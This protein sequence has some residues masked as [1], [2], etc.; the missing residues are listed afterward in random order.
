MTT[1]F[2]NEVAR[3]LGIERKDLIEKDLIL[4]QILLD[5]SEDDFFAPNFL[6]KGGTC[7]QHY[8]PREKQRFSIDLDFSTCF[9]ASGGRAALFGKSS[10]CLKNRTYVRKNE[11]I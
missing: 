1:D 9:D 8:L 4:H 10:L 2:V 3:I 6:L 11:H 7:V 5:L